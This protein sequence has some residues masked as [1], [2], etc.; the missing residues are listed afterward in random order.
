MQD[1]AAASSNVAERFFDADILM[2]YFHVTQ[3]IR[4]NKHKIPKNKFDELMK[5]V[6][7]IHMSTTQSDYD[8]QLLKLKKKYSKKHTVM[9]EYICK[10]WIDGYF[11]KWQIFRSYPGY[12]NTNSN[13]KSFN[14]SIKRDFTLRRRMS[15]PAAIN[16]IYEIINYYSTIEVKFELKPAFDK[17]VVSNSQIYSKRNFKNMGSYV[18]SRYQDE[19]L[20]SQYSIYLKKD[21]TKCTCSCCYFQKHAICKHLLAYGNLHGLN[22]FG[23]KFFNEPIK[24]VNKIKRGPKSGR[25]K[26][27]GKALIRN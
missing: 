4:K 12:A 23:K 26:L 11:N 20:E 5:D 6:E 17:T 7:S 8:N 13:I 10:E 21:L 27:A 19:T 22:I 15:V 18:Q 1:A 16:K 2:C 14:A 9:Y 24:F 25:Y 3:N